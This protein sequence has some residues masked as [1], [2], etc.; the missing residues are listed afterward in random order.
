MLTTNQVRLPLEDFFPDSVALEYF[1]EPTDRGLERN[2]RER[3]ERLRAL[4]RA[5]RGEQR[6]N[7]PMCWTVVALGAVGAHNLNLGI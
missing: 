2:I 1:Y 6:P 3:L 7:M 5:A 4:N